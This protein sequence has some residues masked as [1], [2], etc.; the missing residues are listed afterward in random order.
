MKYWA[1]LLQYR[2]KWDHK[3]QSWSQERVLDKPLGT[4]SI[5]RLDGRLSLA[6]MRA[7]AES[8]CRVRKFDG[9]TI[10]RGESLQ[11]TF[12]V[13]LPKLVKETQP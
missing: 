12:N 5:I 8:M 9:Y 10:I 2:P 11:R 7:V 1:E 6:N 4:F 13:T 3:T